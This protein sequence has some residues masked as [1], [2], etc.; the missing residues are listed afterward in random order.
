MYFCSVCGTSKILNMLNNICEPIIGF[1]QPGES[2]WLINDPN[3]IS[4][5]VTVIITECSTMDGQNHIGLL[6]VC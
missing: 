1:S 2:L 6:T 3:S 5:A 4:W